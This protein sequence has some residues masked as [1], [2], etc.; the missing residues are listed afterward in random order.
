MLAQLAAES[1]FI[2]PQL[3]RLKIAIYRNKIQYKELDTKQRGNKTRTMT[4]SIDSPLH[5]RLQGLFYRL[6]SSSAVYLNL[7]SEDLYQ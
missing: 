1:T 7:F 4:Q 5:Q 3:A 2:P 6:I